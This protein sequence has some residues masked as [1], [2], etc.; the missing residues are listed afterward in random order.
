MSSSQF[1]AE[2]EHLRRTVR[3][4]VET[5]LTPHVAT[6]EAQ[7][8]IPRQIFHRMGELGFLG[9]RVPRAYGG[10]GGDYFTAVVLVEE[11]ARCGAGS[12]PMAVVVQSEMVAPLIVRFGTE[13]QKRRY[14]IPAVRGE[15][16]GALAITEPDAGSDV[17]GLRTTAT[18]VAAG[19]RIT[20]SK[21]FITNGV[22][23]D[24][25]L[26][27]ARTDPGAGHRG[28]SLFL[29]DRGTPGFHVARKLDKLGMR[30][31]DTAE[32]VFDDCLVPA[33]A[34]LGEEHHGFF[35]LMWELQGERLIAAVGAAAVAQLALDLTMASVARRSQ[36]GGSASTSQVDRHRL[37][38]MA[39]HVAAVRQFVYATA[40][41]CNG[42][43]YPVAEV[44]M[45]KLAAARLACRV[46]DDVLQILGQDGCTPDAA[47]ERLWRDA[48]LYRIGAGTDEIMLEIVAKER[49]DKGER[50][51]PA[52]P[53]PFAD[54]HGTFRRTVRRFVQR[55]I[56]PYV[57]EWERQGTV[58]RTLFRK[59]ADAGYLGL[60]CSEADG[61]SDAGPLYEA[62]LHEEVARCGAGG[63]AAAVAVHAGMAV[64]LIARLGTEEQKQRYLFPAL[65]GALIGAMA[66]PRPGVGAEPGVVAGP[67]PLAAGG[68]V[69]SGTVPL[70]VNGACADFV[71]VEARTGSGVRP[72]ATSLFIMEMTGS[73]APVVRTLSAPG[74][75][76]CGTA[77]L[78][79]EGSVVPASNLLGRADQGGAC[80][81][82]YAP[83]GWVLA[84]LQAT[85]TAE[86]ALDHAVSYARARAQF[87]KPLL[88]FQALRHRLA[89]CATEVEVARALTY[90]ALDRYH[91]GEA[92]S[93]DAAMAALVATEVACRVTDEALQIHGG[94]GYMME[95]PVQRLWRD[96]RVGRMAVGGPAGLCEV[97]ADGLGLPRGDQRCS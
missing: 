35:H 1:S 68:Y 57:E 4:F 91:R 73:G 42:G 17:A 51:A 3:H 89:A 20:G 50:R 32:L 80:L 79:W 31:S 58:P 7:G 83:W 28:L 48:R 25:V 96:A 40:G 10:A 27:V 84:A 61:G 85:V 41:R 66:P 53:W 70:V 56:A 75:W 38:H 13:H 46:L 55:E 62:V 8:T 69:L 29:V 44:S 14:L 78:R 52:E 49:F 65:R 19:Y 43:E 82:A 67:A 33:E 71:V 63:V 16:I 97:I 76:A 74:W 12:L 95:Y 87:A 47:V 59:M 36:V 6:W 64:R 90:H 77:E 9:L 5:E 45:A 94:Y 30:A 22:T 39:A 93:Q 72:Q 54:E 15:K 88:A 37:A 81:A 2:H 34:L 18:R 60:G 86:V 23:A 26:V 11:L 92:C 21:M 24:F